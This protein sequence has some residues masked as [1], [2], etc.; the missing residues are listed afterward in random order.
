VT[1]EP[2]E[3]VS[4]WVA[5][6]GVTH[7]VVILPDGKLE[8]VIGVTG[9][10]TAAVFL[11]RE[12]QWKGSAGGS[13]SALSSAQKAGKTDSLYPKKL[14]KIVKAMN[15]GDS[16]KAL[17][18]LRKGK[19]KFKDNDADWAERLD[20]FLIET[21][22]KDFLAAAAAIDKGYLYK[23]VQLASP[24]L[25]KDSLFPGAVDAQTMLDKLED[26]KLYSKEITGGKLY[27]EAKAFEDAKEYLEA[28]KTYKSILKKCGDTQIADHAMT[29][30]KGL[31]SA[32]KPGYKPQCPKCQVNKGAACEKHLEKVKL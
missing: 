4:A 11:G 8:K 23:G 28:V 31:I 1:D 30:A 22:E 20:K 10:P 6:H 26:G 24:Y 13:G 5:K 2:A 7:P 17:A 18:M 19:A 12:M 16:A 21:S 15:E 27:Q 29:A 9:F 3:L 25:G 32:R 14:S